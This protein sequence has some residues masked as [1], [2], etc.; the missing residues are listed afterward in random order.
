MWLRVLSHTTL[1]TSF[2]LR[3]FGPEKLN[4]CNVMVFAFQPSS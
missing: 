3:F 4:Q 2:T 1:P